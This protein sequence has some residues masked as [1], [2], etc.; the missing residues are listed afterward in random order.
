MTPALFRT[1]FGASRREA[2]TPRLAPVPQDAL[3][4]L[5]V[6]EGA[7]ALVEAGRLGESLRVIDRALEI[8]P[9]DADLLF[10]R[11]SVLFAWG[12]YIEARAVLIRS[13]DLGLQSGALHLKL[14]WACLWLGRISEAAASM[15][16]AT[17]AQPEE[18]SAHYGWG[19]VL[20]T[21]K[22]YDESQEAFERAFGLNPASLPC[23]SNLIAGEIQRGRLVC[24][25]AY[26]RRAIELNRE[27]ATAWSDLGVVL[28]AQDQYDAAVAAFEQCE[29]LNQT[30]G[31]APDEFI[32]F[33]ICLLRAGR[34]QEAIALFERR[35]SQHPSVMPH[36]HYAFALLTAGRIT[37][38]WKHY[39]FRWFDEPL[40]SLRLN[41]PKPVWDGQDLRGKTILLRSEQ[42]HGDFIQFI[43]Y[44]EHI[45][46][47]GATVLLHLPES[48]RELA[49]GLDNIDQVL[50]P[51]TPYPPFDFYINLLSIPHVFG[52]DLCTIPADASYLRADVDRVAKWANRFD[53]DETLQ[54]G[55]V[56]AGSPTHFRDRLRSIP[57]QLL[58]PLADVSGVRFY[59]LQKGSA[60]SQLAE[61][62]QKLPVV[63]LDPEL[64]DFA[65]TAAVIAHLDL[66]ITVDTAVA[67]LA[68]AMGKPV[69]TLLPI[70]ADWR[71]MEDFEGTP[72]YPTM[73]LFRQRRQRDW[74]DVIARVKRALEL[75][76]REGPHELSI[77]ANDHAS[78]KSVLPPKPIVDTNQ[79]PVPTL[80][81]AA[82]TRQGLVHY[83]PAQSTVGKSIEW[84]G[85]HLQSQLDLLSRLIAPG[86]VVMEVGAGVGVHALSLAGVIGTDGHL[87]LCEDDPLLRRLLME[88]LTA[89]RVGNVT[90]LKRSLGR[91]T[92]IGPMINE[93]RVASPSDQTPFAD[94]TTDTID[95][96]RLEALHWLKINEESDAL[97]ILQGAAETLWRL[98]PKLFI[99]AHDEQGVRQ[100]EA[101][102]RDLGYQCW[103]L[104]TPYFNPANFNRREADIF[105]GRTALAV[106]A[107]PEES[108]VD[109]ALEG[110]VRLT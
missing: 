35:L 80:G 57:L 28:D 99:A 106:L 43:R 27:S 58:A 37:E 22:R 67:H 45:K 101:C 70:P 81:W 94:S 23:L 8:G 53:N 46:A 95:D 91:I 96:F 98:R 87:I 21:Q 48:L 9:D 4:R 65:D 44:A 11:G 61:A 29:E 63:D 84:Y 71:W 64:L 12:R 83:F 69:W 36:I 54:I 14:G 74:D 104:E 40:R 34:T 19:K 26:A 30:K 73:R 15:H 82:E 72:W 42:G 75:L 10:A 103:K 79:H 49:K 2:K 92:S 52:T 24:A 20:R 39:E 68:G 85:E 97:G 3:K 32:N 41:F 7:V 66:V 100:I 31:G 5:S 47:L 6:I 33:G 93:A 60:A 50:T 108:E 89:N 13:A 51:N 86:S 110:C 77:P 17:K 18:W 25:E 88:N 109:V 76:A 102:A 59:S 38:G 78:Q 105:S 56:W 1:V 90:L 62:P 16:E 107:I 55:I